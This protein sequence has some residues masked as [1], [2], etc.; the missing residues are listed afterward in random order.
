[1]PCGVRDFGPLE[2]SGKTNECILRPRVVDDHQ[3]HKD[4]VKMEANANEREEHEYLSQSRVSNSPSKGRQSDEYVNGDLLADDGRS[5]SRRDA[6]RQPLL[7]T[8][9]SMHSF[10]E[11]GNVMDEG[12]ESDDIPDEE[13]GFDIPDN[14]MDG[15]VVGPEDNDDMEDAYGGDEDNDPYEHVGTQSGDNEEEDGNNVNTQRNCKSEAPEGNDDWDAGLKSLLEEIA[16]V[17]ENADDNSDHPYGQEEEEGSM[18]YSKK[19]RRSERNVSSTTSGKFLLQ[20]RRRSSV[21]MMRMSI[22]RPMRPAVRKQFHSYTAPHG[23]N[24][25]SFMTGQNGLEKDGNE[26]RDQENVGGMKDEAE[27]KEVKEEADLTDEELAAEI[28]ST[29]PSASS[30]Y[31]SPQKSGHFYRVSVS[32][33]HK[34]GVKKMMMIFPYKMTIGDIQPECGTMVARDYQGRRLK[35]STKIWDLVSPTDVHVWY[36]EK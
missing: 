15:V 13:P 8:P 6:N 12:G 32:Y 34:N 22:D 26:E 7:G 25:L 23:D 33:R 17:V 28:E 30:S 18:S 10:P 35:P 27:K 1:V 5:M 2:K 21:G 14:G 29:W 31:H 20:P 11:N 19:P 16:P 9:R 24:Q 4:K 3:R 36:T